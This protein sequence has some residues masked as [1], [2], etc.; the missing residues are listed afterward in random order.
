MEVTKCDRCGSYVDVEPMLL[1]LITYRG[2]KKT[3]DELPSA[4]HTTLC[5]ECYN[6]F[7]DWVKPFDQEEKK[8][9]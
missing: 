1:P 4:T 3:Y 2:A 9:G 8:E 7:L 5:P 6:R